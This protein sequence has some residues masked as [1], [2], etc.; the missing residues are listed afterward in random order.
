MMEL[1]T[2]QGNAV[3]LS[4]HQVS[5]LTTHQKAPVWI[6]VHQSHRNGESVYLYSGDKA[7][8]VSENGLQTEP[9]LRLDKPFE[10]E[11]IFLLLS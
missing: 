3:R 11:K 9:N 6:V 7:I 4:P 5:F 2:T 10:W 1:K 8:A